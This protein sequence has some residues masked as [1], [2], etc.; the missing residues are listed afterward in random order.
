MIRNTLYAAAVIAVSVF[1]FSSFYPGYLTAD[2]VYI[3]NM[4]SGLDPVSNWHPNFYVWL[5]KSLLALL[6]HVPGLWLAQTAALLASA[7]FA[8][9]RLRYLHVVAFLAI[10]LLPP[11]AANMA[12]LW[13]DDWAVIATLASL[14]A[15]IRQRENIASGRTEG[16][17]GRITSVIPGA[18]SLIL[19]A[20]ASLIRLDYIVIVLP[21]VAAAS[22]WMAET[23]T[24]RSLSFSGRAAMSV[25]GFLTL[26]VLAFAI[27]AVAHV[28]VESQQNSWVTILAWD[29]AG[30]AARSDHPVSMYH[31]PVPASGIKAAYN[32]RTS[33]PLVFGTAPLPMNQPDR[34]QKIPADMEAHE[35]VTAWLD[36]VRSQP[37]SYLEH[38]ACVLTEYLGLG[39]APHYPFPFGV[40][41]NRLGVSFERTPANIALYFIYY[42]IADSVM[43]RPWFWLLIVTLASGYIAASGAP[44]L[45]FPLLFSALASAARGL[46]VPAADVRYALWIF[47]A[48]V[49]AAMIALDLAVARRGTAGS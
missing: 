26:A 35:Y 47:V 48:A 23:L 3:L 16:P 30:V 37:I 41:P 42:P 46:I 14:S 31:T 9:R 1:Y 36:A 27:R 13:K 11:V 20:L 15:A 19:A 10:T 39:D 17:G 25:L 2:S 44:S 5:N 22:W 6:Q 32:C 43:F 12:A 28:N 7:V 8:S 40:V 29:I 18:A 45:A 33:D 24:E 49:Y 38:R 34:E 4:V 21:V